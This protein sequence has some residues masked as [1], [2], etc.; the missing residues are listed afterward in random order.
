LQPVSEIAARDWELGALVHVDACPGPP[1]IDPPAAEFGLVSFAG[2]KLG[3]G[4]GGLLKASR[5][6]R[7]EPLAYGGPQERSRRAGHEDVAGATAV[8][9]AL[10]MCATHREAASAAAR[11]LA[12]RLRQVL[13]H[14][15]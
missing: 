12:V 5:D 4:R 3:A 13:E 7:L 1:W 10:E 11:P 15:G 14:G 8:A 9:V 2:H 6:V